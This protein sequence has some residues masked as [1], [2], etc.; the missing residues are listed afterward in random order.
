MD[1]T[2]R[3]INKI[4]WKPN[5]RQSVFLSIPWSIKEAMY[6]G[7]A[8]SGKSD[9]L[10]MYGIVHRFHENPK[11]KQVFMRRTT[12]D[13]KKEIVPRSREIYRHFG[14]TFNATDMVW[15]FPRPD[16]FGSGQRNA[17]A[18]I[19]LAHCEEEKDV[20]NFDSM[21]ISLFTPD[22][23]TLLTEYIYTYVGFERNRAPLNSGLPSIIRTAGMPGGI[24]HRFVK[25]RFVDPAPFGEKIIIG[26][27]G[28][29]RIYIHA[30]LAD[31]PFIDPTYSQSLDGRPEAERKAKKFGDWSAYL[32]QVFDEFRDKHYTDEPDNALH[33]IEPFEIPY[34]WPRFVIGDWGFRAM[35]Y[36]MFCAVSPSGRLYVYRELYFTQ[37][38][39]EEWAPAIKHYI[40]NENIKVVKFCKSAGQQRGQEHTIQEQISDA[41]GVEIELSDNSAGQRVAGKMLIHE[42]LRWKALP[43]LPSSEMPIYS[44]E[45]AMFLLRNKGLDEYKSYLK[46]FDP[47]TAESDLPKLQIFCCSSDNHEG[48]PL[49]CPVLV[50]S[51][52]ACNYDK[53]RNNKPAEDVMEFEG[54]DPYDTLRYAVATVDDYVNE[55]SHS[56]QELK[57]QAALME[58]VDRNPNFTMMH[59]LSASSESDED[60]TVVRRFHK[61]H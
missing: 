32:G 48:H 50:D 16:Q 39:I 41:L 28:N 10:L 46:L 2:D 60:F 54:D 55:S 51:I 7:G 31:N 35:T 29:K 12:P 15:T 44:E 8:G 57:R 25:T 19:F 3:V 14:A 21:E 33:C 56:F 42:Y 49:C 61:S 43:I 1:N 5:K 53:P 9:V 4:E 58:R 45:T 6:G 52:K 24:G 26:K 23:V 34:W 59:H 36:I 22:E 13:L 37:T 38:K 11:F 47:P 40:E 18:M 30:T 17:G 27:G 20:H